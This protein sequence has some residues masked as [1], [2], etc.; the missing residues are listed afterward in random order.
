[1]C[2][3]EHLLPFIFNV[4]ILKYIF[5]FENKWSIWNIGLLLLKKLNNIVSLEA[6][7][8]WAWNEAFFSG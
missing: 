5:T 8:N 6:F 4:Q 2:F 3:F 7:I 1:M